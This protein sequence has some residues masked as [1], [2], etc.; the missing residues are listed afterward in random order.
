MTTRDMVTIGF[1]GL[2]FS[3]VVVWAAL[4]PANDVEQAVTL[5]IQYRAA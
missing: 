2:V 3:S 4:R 1:Y 5:V